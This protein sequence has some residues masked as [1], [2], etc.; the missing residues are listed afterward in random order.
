[1]R[2]PHKALSTGG[3]QPLPALVVPKPDSP[4]QVILEEEGGSE[5][6]EGTKRRKLDTNSKQWVLILITVVL[7]VLEQFLQ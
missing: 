4:Q 3:M 7:Q 5:P 2:S 1:M 6:E